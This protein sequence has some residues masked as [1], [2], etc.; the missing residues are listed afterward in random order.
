M[1]ALLVICFFWT[2]SLFA[3]GDDE[4]GQ[5]ASFAKINEDYS[6]GNVTGY[7]V[8]V[9]EMFNNYYLTS[10]TLVIKDTFL[11]DL[12]FTE[13]NSYKGYYKAFFQV[14]PEKLDLLNIV[15]GYS[16]TQDKKGIV[17]CG[18]RIQLNLKELLRANRPEAIIAIPPPLK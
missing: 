12:N 6:V 7:N 10:F 3:C 5:L 8:Y 18:E 15:L 17:M 9:P 13:A 14:N 4:L 2:N 16:T 11:G 1:R